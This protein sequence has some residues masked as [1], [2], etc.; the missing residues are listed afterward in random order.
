MTKIADRDTWFEIETTQ[1]VEH[2]K[3]PALT[4]AD[5]FSQKYPKK[6]DNPSCW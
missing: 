5:P 6:V 1:H 2:E 4:G 3:N